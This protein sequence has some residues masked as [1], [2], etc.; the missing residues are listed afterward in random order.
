MRTV[1]RTQEDM[2]LRVT[3][4]DRWGQ[5]DRLRDAYEVIAL[6]TLQILISLS[7]K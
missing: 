1:E 4:G 7:E 3:V 6:Y 5:A 2:S